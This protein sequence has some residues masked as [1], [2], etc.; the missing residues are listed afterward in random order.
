MTILTNELFWIALS[1]SVFIAAIMHKSV[2]GKIYAALDQRIKKAVS[3][4]VEAELVKKSAQLRLKETRV[5]YNTIVETNSRILQ[6]AQSDAQVLLSEANKK[7]EDLEKQKNSLIEGYQNAQN[8]EI[9][10][11]LKS[12]VLVAA[13]NIVERK[14]ESLL[15]NQSYR[16][17]VEDLDL[18]IFKKTWN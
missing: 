9:I 3:D 7:I 15:K 14:F 1:F 10:E 16:T 18:E 6:L 17:E 2:K 4:V 5:R 11:A 12:D 8:K 13:L